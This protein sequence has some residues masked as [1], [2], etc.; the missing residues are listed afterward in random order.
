[1]LRT[2]AFIPA[3]TRSLVRTELRLMI[4]STCLTCGEGRLVSSADGSLDEWE[5][6]HECKVPEPE[7]SDLE[8]MQFGTH[9]IWNTCKVGFRRN[10]CDPTEMQALGR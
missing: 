4:L 10:Q 5:D 7:Q 9:A 2:D 6:G 8:H 3:F 1:M